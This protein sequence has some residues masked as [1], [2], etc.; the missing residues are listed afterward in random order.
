MNT[1]D[2]YDAVKLA[3]C[4][5]APEDQCKILQWITTSGHSLWGWCKEANDSEKTPEQAAA[6][7][8]N[9]YDEHRNSGYK[10][11][12]LFFLR[13]EKILVSLGVDTQV[14][15]PNGT[16]LW[17]FSDAYWEANYTPEIAAK[18]W[19][20]EL[21]LT[22][23]S[24]EKSTEKSRESQYFPKAHRTGKR[25]IGVL[26]IE[27]KVYKARQTKATQWKQSKISLRSISTATTGSS[28]ST[29]GVS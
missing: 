29:S 21:K 10:N 2:Y 28:T 8:I 17:D 23:K 27:N 14:R 12:V 15:S 18:D 24:T 11:H 9:K 19:Q 20:T 6:T 13:V 22:K 25:S 26:T 3:V 1:F 16:S 5:S 7:W 4:R